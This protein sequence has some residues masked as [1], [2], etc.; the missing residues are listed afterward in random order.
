MADMYVQKKNI[1]LD[2]YQF[3]TYINGFLEFEFSNFD[4]KHGFL[5][6]IEP[7]DKQIISFYIIRQPFSFS[8]FYV[9]FTSIH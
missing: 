1:F 6:S 4:P 3:E 9:H 7:N 2:M 8:A 5:S